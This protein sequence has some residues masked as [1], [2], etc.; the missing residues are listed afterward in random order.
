MKWE[1]SW[2]VIW[3]DSFFFGNDDICMSGAI[4]GLVV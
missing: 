2:P 3:E 4:D 1:S